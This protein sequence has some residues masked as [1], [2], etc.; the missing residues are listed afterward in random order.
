MKKNLLFAF[1]LSV[2]SVS[3]YS[4]VQSTTFGGL[5]HDP[6][7]W[8]GL[9]VPGENDDVI[10][11]GPVVQA[12]TSGY[13]ILPVHCNNL[14][15]TSSGS[16]RNGGYGGGNGIFPVYVH[17]SAV[18]NGIVENGGEDALKMFVYG[19]LTNNNIW[20]PVETEL[21]NSGNH[22]L[23]LLEGMTFGSKIIVNSSTGITAL[24][25]L[26]FTC[27]WYSDGYYNRSHLML[28]GHIF[29]V[30]N[31][32]LEM[33]HCL[34]NS[35]TLTGDFEIL[36][37]FKVGYDVSDTL[38]F[39]GN[40][41]VTD[42]LMANVYGGGYGIY[43]LRINGN[44]L[45]N[46]V[47]MDNMDTKAPLNDD[48]LEILITGD[49]INNRHWSCKYVKLAGDETQHIT[50]GTDRFFDSYFSDLNPESDIVAQSNITIMNDLNLNGAH[51]NMA[52]DTLTIYGWLYG[53]AIE[54]TNLNNGFLNN[55]ISM[56]GLSV[57]GV[58]TIENNNI[59]HDYVIVNDTLQS[60]EYGG[61]SITYTLQVRGDI[62]NYGLIRNINDGDLLSLEITGGID[63]HGLWENAYTKFSGSQQQQIHQLPGKVFQTNFTDVDSV[64][65]V[66]ATS[67]LK[68]AGN[69]NLLRS[70][71]EMNHYEID[72]SGHLYNGRVNSAIIKN[73]TLSN[74]TASGNTEI[75]GIV[76]IDDGN[77][78]YGNL[79]VTDT[80][81]SQVY[82][83]G[84]YTYSLYNF[85]NIEN[86]GLIRNEPTQ[87]E[88][89]ALYVQGDIINRGTF[90]NYAN[91]QLFYL[92]DDVHQV[93]CMNN[94]TTNW[95]FEGADITGAGAESFSMISGGGI[96]TV[97][98]G[99]SWEVSVQFVPAG[100][101]FTAQLNIHCTETGSLGTIYLIGY[102][103]NSTVG[104]KDPGVL[105]E[106]GNSLMFRNYPNPFTQGT[107]IS[108]HQ[109]EKAHVVLKLYDFTGKEMC[110]LM[111]C[112]R[113]SGEHRFNYDAS[114][115]PSG[116]YFL[117]GWFDDCTSAW[118][119]LKM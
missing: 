43:K 68:I 57:N 5:W 93:S 41:T 107:T 96:Q 116:I 34:V 48:D 110:T 14:T 75:R 23:S 79:L 74:I 77:R 73:A 12:Y 108:W 112:D 49:I 9:T 4:Q 51:L 29:S 58:V 62:T 90:T 86:N 82:G 56:G 81:Q 100:S 22:N 6:N 63:N 25:D 94:G 2:V 19:D 42:T 39:N 87:N 113:S 92:N 67:D 31:H 17:G 8:I 27:D 1:I 76:V 101:V 15:I 103:E 50:Q 54:N 45:N 7:T 89:F 21:T 66:V 97:P 98:P 36:G 105:N 60:I 35:G 71:L 61:G 47:I 80:L 70:T 85:G 40:I 69:C 118:K 32:S 33:R 3:V 119:M 99:E 20:M 59:F 16:L 102:N 65:M 64:S 84:S 37:T 117:K 95:Q 53:G 44:L 46:G 91:Y 38:K 26:V 111:D 114:K 83:G 72:I 88:S 106:Q 109:P 13:A 28:N 11:N 30:G 55:I 104:V 18:N 78:F 52:G 24:T 10:I 115:L